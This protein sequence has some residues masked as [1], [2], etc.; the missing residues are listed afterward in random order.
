MG[1]LR[2][3]LFLSKWWCMKRFITRLFSIVSGGLS[4]L[5]LFSFIAIATDSKTPDG[6]IVATMI[7]CILMFIFALF[8][9]SLWTLISPKAVLSK[10][11]KFKKTKPLTQPQSSLYEDEK[12]ENIERYKPQVVT[13]ETPH[14]SLNDYQ[15]TLTGRRL[16]A[17]YKLA[18]QILDDDNVDLDE[19]KKL[20]SWLRRYPES[21]DD[22]RTKKLYLAAEA[23]LE[24]RQLDKDESLE[25]FALLSEFCDQYEDDFQIQIKAEIKKPKKKLKIEAPQFIEASNEEHIYP[26]LN[27]LEKGHEYFLEYADSKGKLSERNIIFRSVD[28]N[29]S[30]QP[31]IKA[32]CTLRHKVRTFRVDR[33]RA[34]VD[35]DTGEAFV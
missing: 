31:Y 29:Q 30:E 26:F 27:T 10:L 6:W 14:E 35:L 17:F 8:S 34:L 19:A 1:P 22:S 20:R 13:F 32:V 18:L 28:T 7:T 2:W 33:I 16:K 3:A 4:L 9:Y 15:E 5:F 12:N 23:V 11:F 24:D 21:K 25:L